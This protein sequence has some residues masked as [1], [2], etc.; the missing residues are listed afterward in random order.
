MYNELKLYCKSE[1]LTEYLRSEIKFNSQS[2]NAAS[3]KAKDVLRNAE[4]QNPRPVKR[5]V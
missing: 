5:A 2:N 4:K 3:N 1:G